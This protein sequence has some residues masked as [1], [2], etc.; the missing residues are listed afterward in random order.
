VRLFHHAADEEPPAVVRAVEGE[1]E[2]LLPGREIRGRCE[3]R[4]R[5][6][7][8]LT[9]IVQLKADVVDGRAVGLEVGVVQPSIHNP[10]SPRSAGTSQILHTMVVLAMY[11]AA[12][13]IEGGYEPF[14]ATI[15]APLGADVRAAVATAAYLTARARVVAAEIA[16]LDQR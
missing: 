3:Q 6:Q 11:D 1:P 16:P 2:P 4:R 12:V 8:G 15:Q 5:A 14:A 10:A 13:A 7:R 9:R